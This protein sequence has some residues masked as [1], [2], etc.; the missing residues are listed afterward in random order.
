MDLDRI[1]TASGLSLEL[2]VSQATASRILK[3]VGGGTRIGNLTLYP[4][5]L[6]QAHLLD[7]NAKLLTFLGYDESPTW[8]VDAS[9][10]P[11]QPNR[12]ESE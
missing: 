5:G 2:G 3:G 9:E 6:V 7:K 10:E 11:T 1:I 8:W 12:Q 4:R